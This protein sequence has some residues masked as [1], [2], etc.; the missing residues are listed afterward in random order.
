MKKGKL[1]AL[2]L[3]LCML[4]LCMPVTAAGLIE[5]DKDVTLSINSHYNKTPLE[6]VT[7]SLYLIAETDERGELLPLPEFEAF[8]LEIRGQNDEAWMAATTALQDHVEGKQLKPYTTG[9]T[10]A[11]GQLDLPAA[12][13]TLEKGLYLVLAEPHVQG[14]DTYEATPFLVMLPTMDPVEN[15]WIYDVSVNAKHTLLPRETVSRTV[16]KTWNDAGNED[17]RP[18]YVRVSLLKNGEVYDTVDIY[19][20]YWTYTW[21]GLDANAVW[22]IE[23]HKT[24]GYIPK[25]SQVDD[26][27]IITNT[28]TPEIPYTGTSDWLIPL[29]TAFGA[30]MAVIGWTM[31]RNSKKKK[32]KVM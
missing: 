10:N 2:W 31:N 15:I 16:Q 23:E 1:T 21:E 13:E 25:I 28:Y 17:I 27:F 5:E 22:T 6:G 24:T 8:E 7:F 19:P 32:E 30:G 3:C 11:E 26:V 18:L 29:L 9:V 20:P 12:A 14:I 4:L